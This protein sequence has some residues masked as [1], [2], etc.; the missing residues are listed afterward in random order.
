MLAFFLPENL[1]IFRAS[2]SSRY[3]YGQVDRGNFSISV[4]FVKKAF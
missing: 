4:G 3:R 2:F 1:P